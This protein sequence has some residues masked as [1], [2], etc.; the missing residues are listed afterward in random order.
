MNTHVRGEH[1]LRNGSLK[2]HCFRKDNIV[3]NVKLRYVEAMTIQQIFLSN[4][5]FELIKLR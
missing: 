3:F 1:V 2:K 5:E 4:L